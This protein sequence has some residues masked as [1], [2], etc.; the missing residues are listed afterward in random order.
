[1][2]TGGTGVMTD[3]IAGMNGGTM[4]ASG[5]RVIA[6]LLIVFVPIGVLIQISVNAMSRIADST[7]TS[8]PM[9]P[10][11]AW[12]L[13]LT[14]GAAI[15][16]LLPL[17]WFAVGLMR[18]DRLG[19]PLTIVGHMLGSIVFSLLHVAAMSA[20]RLLLW[21][22][23]EVRNP[24]FSMLVYEYR[25]DAWTYL[26][27]GSFLALARW[28]TAGNSAPVAEIQRAP[29]VLTVQDGRTRQQIPIDRIDYVEAAGN[30]VEIFTQG[31]RLLH[32]TTLTALAIEL[33]DGFA[34][35]HRSRLVNRSVVRNVKINQAG[36]F[37]IEVESGDRLKGSRRFR[38]ML[39][40]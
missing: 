37:E 2:T 35:I 31:H 3:N 34:Q 23:A 20:M 27:I 38:K 26:L 5:N 18:P 12:A 30:Y 28:M 29:A 9:A 1:M 33:G 6:R 24:S 21:K 36:D 15:L 22:G 11:V 4:G 16:L 13:E 7:A 40:A 14:S 39:D 10:R 19:W 8:A 17:I 32:R 25:K